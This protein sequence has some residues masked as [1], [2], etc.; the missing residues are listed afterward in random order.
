MA[1]KPLR[2][3]VKDV[4]D[5]G[6]RGRGD[7]TYA[8]R[9]KPQR[10]LARFIEKPFSREFPAALLDKRHER[11][12]ACWLQ[13]LDDDLIDGS[14]GID[15]DLAGHDDFQTLPRLGLKPREDSFPNHRIDAGG[16]VLQTEIGV[17]GS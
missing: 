10:P 1:R 9:Q 7:D 4:A 11:A 15:C 8:R 12:D 3:A 16:L 14:V 2:D 13:R 17:A 5:D 6:S